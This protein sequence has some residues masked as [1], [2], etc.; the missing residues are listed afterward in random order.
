MSLV[1]RTLPSG[2]QGTPTELSLHQLGWK[3]KDANPELQGPEDPARAAGS[4]HLL[5]RN[6]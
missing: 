3:G 1:E 4:D 5:L 2:L 6:D